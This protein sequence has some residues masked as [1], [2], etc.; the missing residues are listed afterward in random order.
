MTNLVI[1]RQRECPLMGADVPVYDS[2]LC[3]VNLSEYIDRL[4]Y[5]TFVL[6]LLMSD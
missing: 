1:K 4:A 2:S 6:S 3:D 5:I